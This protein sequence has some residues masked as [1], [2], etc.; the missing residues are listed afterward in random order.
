MTVYATTL[1]E[2]DYVDLYAIHTTEQDELAE[3]LARQ[4]SELQYQLVDFNITWN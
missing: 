2:V 1:E 3:Y 4:L